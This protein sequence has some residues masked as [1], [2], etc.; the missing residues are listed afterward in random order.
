MTDKQ[1]TV[2]NFPI[3]DDTVLR[4]RGSHFDIGYEISNHGR[5]SDPNTSFYK[6]MGTWCYYVLIFEDMIDAQS[7]E[8]F[9]LAPQTHKYSPTG[10]DHIAYS[11]TDARFAGVRWHGGVTYYEKLG[12]ID[13]NPRGVKIGCDFSHYWDDGYEYDYADV[14]REAKQTIDEMRSMYSFK[15]RCAWNGMW[16][17]E[18]EMVHDEHGRLYSR[19]GKEE[20][21]ASRTK[22]APEAA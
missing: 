19:I 20:R 7:F 4:A 10:R 1:I 8:Q 17:P 13:G 6:P 21:D 15:R 5:R 2:A 11:Y 16:F 18:S 9:W 14:D 3:T 22:R 12:G